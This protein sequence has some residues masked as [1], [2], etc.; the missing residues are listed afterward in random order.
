MS[1]HHDPHEAQ[2]TAA[3]ERLAERAEPVEL[4]LSRD[5]FIAYVQALCD[6]SQWAVNEALPD[7]WKRRMRAVD[8]LH[9]VR[10]ELHGDNIDTAYLW[11]CNESR[12]S[13]LN[14]QSPY[15]LRL[16]PELGGTAVLALDEYRRVGPVQWQLSAAR[17]LGRIIEAV[18]Q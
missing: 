16:S 5:E 4:P 3:A 10:E 13:V 18:G 12:A 11:A 15:P 17:L 14:D 8:L 7:D 9:S 1:S 2:A 6:Y